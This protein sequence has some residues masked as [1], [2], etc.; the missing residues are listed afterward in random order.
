MTLYTNFIGIDI[1]K[2]TF[3]V[4]QHGSKTTTE[5]EN[6]AEGIAQFMAHYTP[7]L[8]DGLC[9]VEATGGYENEVIH[10]LLAASFNVHRADTRKVKAFI[11]S[12]GNGAKTDALDA[13]ALAKYGCER[14]HYLPLF[15]LQPQENKEL[16][17]L[18]QRYNDLQAMIRA[19]KNRLQ[20]PGG[21]VIKESIKLLIKNLEEQIQAIRQAIA[22]V[23]DTNAA[24]KSKKEI[25][26]Q[27]PGIGDN[28]AAALLS[29]LP[30]LGQIDRRKISCLAGLAPRANESGKFSGYRRTGHGRDGIKPILFMAAMAARNSHSPLK[31]YYESLIKRGKKKMVALVALMRKILVI[32]NAKIKE[33]NL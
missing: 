32:A 13:K 27:V 3:V 6:S 8:Q 10:A 25:L 22:Q 1:G 30:E 5:H 21:E 23:I 18:Q 9:I 7:E 31:A 19:E 17:Q 33:L 20:A 28:V 2:F 14:G 15:H 24:L 4:A 11:R 12:L 26:K 29:L 16:F